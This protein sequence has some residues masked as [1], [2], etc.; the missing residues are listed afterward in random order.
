MRTEHRT[1]RSCLWD[2]VLNTIFRFLPFINFTP[3]LAVLWGPGM[4][5][6]CL[7]PRATPL[8]CSFLCTSVSLVIQSEDIN[9]KLESTY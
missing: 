1:G 8:D 9:T 3:A 2:S 6:F 4:R 5:Q 7:G